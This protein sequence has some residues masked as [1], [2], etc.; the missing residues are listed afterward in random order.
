LVCSTLLGARSLRMAELRHLRR[1]SSVDVEAWRA[2]GYAEAKQ[3]LEHDLPDRMS[4]NATT[5]SRSHEEASVRSARAAV[6]VSRLHRIVNI[7]VSAS[8]GEQTLLVHIYCC[9][10]PR[11]RRCVPEN[12][13]SSLRQ[14]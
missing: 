4:W 2:P 10:V 6:L 13:Q 8:V 12:T 14:V 3:Y 1:G 11:E 9:K 5:N 7:C